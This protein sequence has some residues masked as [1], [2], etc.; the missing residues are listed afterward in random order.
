VPEK[1]FFS[2]FIDNQIELKVQAQRWRLAR[3]Y[4]KS[5]SPNLAHGIP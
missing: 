2:Q 4:L 1:A 3:M 5:A